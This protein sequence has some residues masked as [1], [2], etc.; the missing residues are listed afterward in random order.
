[1]I[2]I[3]PRNT[4]INCGISSRAEILKILP[5]LVNLLSWLSANTLVDNIATRIVKISFINIS[6][7]E[8][9]S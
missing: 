2:D 5:N 4:F 7:K 3:S 9:I 1:M 6:L 8:L